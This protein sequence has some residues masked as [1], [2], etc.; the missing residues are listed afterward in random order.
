MIGDTERIRAALNYVPAHERET[1]V[2]MGMAVK[3]ELGDAGFDVWDGWSQQADAYN[4]GDARDV[5][6]S[7]RGNGKVTT[8]TLFHEAKA[9]GWR[10]DGTYRVPTSEEVAERRRMATER[11][12]REEAEQSR[13]RAGAAKTAA[14]I[15]KAAPP[16]DSAHPYVVGK[17]VKSHGLRLHK[18]TLVVPMRAADGALHSLQFIDA[19]GTKRFLT[20]GRVAGCYFSIGKPD[21]RICVAEGYATGASIHEVTGCAVAVAFDA[22]NLRAAA[23]AIKAKYPAATLILCADDDCGTEGN[24]GITKATEAALAVGALL[25]V[26]DFGADRPEGATDFNDLA[27]HRGRGAVERAVANARPPEVEVAR[28]ATPN[29]SEAHFGLCVLN[30]AELLTREFPEREA[31]LKPWLLTQSLSLIHAYRGVGKTHV[32]L[33]IAYAVA[34]GEKYLTWEAP[35]PRR[36]LYIDGEM[37]AAAIRDRLQALVDADEREFD[38]ANL[39]IVTPDVQEGAMPDLATEGGQEAI[40][41]VVA[42][43]DIELIIVDNIATLVRNT[44]RGENETESWRDVQ[45]WALRQR[46]RQRSVLFVHHDGKGGKQRGTSARE[47]TLDAVIQLKHPSDYHPEEGAKFEIHFR[48]A[49]N[50]AG[51]DVKPIEAELIQGQDGQ[52]T[53]TWRDLEESTYTKVVGLANDGLRAVDIATELEISKSTVSRHL[54]RARQAGLIKEASK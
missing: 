21:D 15:W 23:E 3:S 49:R 40:E 14:A 17:G 25:A 12:A 33:G 4:A 9:N 45:T 46:Q 13:E 44:A 7:I 29:A 34:T 22:G 50:L 37:P 53:W 5:W 47:D 8:G 54:K 39:L 28:A 18:G 38:P 35:R 52:M 6:R 19:D 51:K 11:A 27:A 32:A 2:R 30:L 31:I 43:H 41:A 42:K 1:W 20:G 10:D 16:A 36:V 26:P 48:K 24:P